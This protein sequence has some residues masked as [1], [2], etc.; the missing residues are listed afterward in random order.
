MGTHG[1]FRVPPAHNEPAARV[2]AGQPRA[3]FAAGAARRDEGRADRDPARDRRQGRHHRHDEA[4]RDAARPRARARR[5]APGRRRGDE[6]GDRRRRRGVEGLVALAVGGAGDRLPARRRAARRALAR[7]AGRGDDA[8]PVEDV[9]AGR[10]RR[11]L[12]ARRLPALQRRVHDPDL[13]R[14]ARLVP[15]GVEPDGLPAARGLRLRGLAVQLHGDRR[16]PDVVG[17]ADGERRPLEAGVDRDAERLLLHAAAPGS[18][19]PRRRDQ[20]RLRAPAPRSATW[21]SR[22]ATSPASTSPAR[23]ACSTACGGPSPATWTTT[24]TTHGSSARR[25]ARTSSSPTPPPTSTP[26]RPRSSAGSFE[27]QGQKCSAA[28]RVYAPSNLWPELRE[29]LQEQVATI[30]VGDVADFAQLHGRGD[31]RRLVRDAA[32]GDRRGA[33]ARGNGDRRRRRHRRLEG[34]LRRADG[35]RDARPGVPA[36]AR[37]ALRPGRDDVRLRRERAGTTRST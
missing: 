8:R 27:Y 11:G 16:Q 4:G 30:K 12:R 23:P 17:G 29:R 20:P 10:D 14:A 18:R 36:A 25:A 24:A 28:S 19:A 7:H 5:R 6:A 2:R 26:S 22:A 9:A 31:R 33:V 15:R 3:R 32:R 37:R 35:D 21:R 13:L 34:L 1:I